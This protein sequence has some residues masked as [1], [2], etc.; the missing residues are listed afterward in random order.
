MYQCPGLNHL[1]GNLKLRS[2]GLL[3]KLQAHQLPVSSALILVFIFSCPK[4]FVAV[5]KN[6]DNLFL[7]LPGCCLLEKEIKGCL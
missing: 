1:I 6:V 3:S 7:H 5:N 2:L 4:S